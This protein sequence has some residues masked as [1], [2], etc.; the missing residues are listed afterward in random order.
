MHDFYLV[1]AECYPIAATSALKV[2]QERG[3]GARGYRISLFC[4]VLVI[5]PK[6][7]SSKHFIST[8]LFI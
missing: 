7:V 2:F 8:L 5:F 6:F 4:S 3:R 1:L